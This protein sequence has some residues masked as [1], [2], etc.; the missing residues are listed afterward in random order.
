[1]FEGR[2]SVSLEAI[3]YRIPREQ[4]QL[5]DA[6]ATYFKDHFYKH[7]DVHGHMITR[8]IDHKVGNINVKD[9]WKLARQVRDARPHLREQERPIAMLMDALPT[10]PSLQVMLTVVQH[11]GPSTPL[12]AQH[13]YT[14]QE[15]WPI[16][17]TTV[18]EMLKALHNK[19]WIIFD[20]D[21]ITSTAKDQG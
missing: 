20:G 1:M 11:K 10:K 15:G 3:A 5:L 13:Q 8:K 18:I 2:R 19:R 12:Q 4:T 16:P 14:L 6:M 17:I 7:Y 9:F 21:R